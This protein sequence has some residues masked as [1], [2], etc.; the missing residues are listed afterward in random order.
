MTTIAPAPP[1]DVRREIPGY[2][3]VALRVVQE[4]GDEKYAVYI[5]ET[6]GASPVLLSGRGQSIPAA[7]YA[8]LVRRGINALYLKTSDYDSYQ[9]E[10]QRHLDDVL[11]REDLSPSDQMDVL[12]SAV[13][14]AVEKAF[15]LVRVDHAIEQSERIGGK[16]VRLCSNPDLLPRDVYGVLRHDHYTFTHLINVSSYCVMLAEHIGI[17]DEADLNAIAA[18]GL[19]HD[20]G[21]R[22]IPKHILNK[23]GKLSGEELAIMRKHPQN[24]YEE[25]HAREE[26]SRGQ[27]MMVYQHHEHVD[28]SGYPV[29][30]TGNDI[31]TW[32]KICAV[33]D[34]FDA[35]TCARPYRDAMPIDDVLKWM[36]SRAGTHLDA[37][38][39]R[40]W[41][42]EMQSK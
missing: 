2:V 24:G 36:G 39:L 26:L 33:V 22:L 17:C 30:V 7:K 37:E 20:V 35:M 13:G 5:A 6:E 3:P 8:E 34:V 11:E 21:K 29:G 10:V 25:L 14:P 38:I 19:L 9:Q 31:H 18:G 15:S 42:M 23:P 1:R 28:G 27:L 4:L 40:C 12:Q 32:A 41:T 16:I